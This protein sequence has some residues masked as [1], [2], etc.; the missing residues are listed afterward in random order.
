MRKEYEYE[1]KLEKVSPEDR[2]KM[3]EKHAAEAKKHKDHPK[4]HHPGSKPQL[5]EVYNAGKKSVSTATTVF[6]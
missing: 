4:L 2:K 1:Q 3:E 5:E 6:I